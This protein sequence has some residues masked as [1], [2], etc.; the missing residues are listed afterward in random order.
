MN[1]K[2]KRQRETSRREREK[3]KAGTD[4]SRPLGSSRKINRRTLWY[5]QKVKRQ[6]DP[7]MDTA[8]SQLHTLVFLTALLSNTFQCEA[9]SR[10][11]FSSPLCKHG[12]G[13]S[14][15]FREALDDVYK[16]NP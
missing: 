15:N 8:F 5:Q 11:L 13:G 9:A 7:I 4:V 16:K 1:W 14:T 12:D 2:K 10:T 3:K 6:R